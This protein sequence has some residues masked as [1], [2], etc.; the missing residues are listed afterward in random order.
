MNQTNKFEKAKLITVK[1]LSRPS[2]WMYFRLGNATRVC[3]FWF[4]ITW[5][6]PWLPEVAF[7]EGWNAAFRQIFMDTLTDSLINHPPFVPKSFEQIEEYIRSLPWSDDTPDIH[8]TLV[9][10]NI[11]A[12]Y[13]WL[14]RGAE[15]P[16]PSDTTLSASEALY[17]FMGWITGFDDQVTFSSTHNAS[18]AAE[19]VDEFVKINNLAEPRNEWHIKL[20]HPIHRR[21]TFR[22]E[23]SK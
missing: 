15:M 11:R 3:F 19:L 6:R 16:E 9:A 10:G 8:K 14:R 21:P 1:F 20:R 5:R 4:E 23:K 7:T 17:G 13:S 18:L 22:E 12:F 2:R